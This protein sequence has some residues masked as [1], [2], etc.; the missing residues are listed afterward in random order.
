MF[1]QRQASRGQRGRLLLM[2]LS[3]CLVVITAAGCASRA[4]LSAAGTAASKLPAVES[5]P[6]T[7]RPTANP[8]DA[9]DPNLAPDE[10]GIA[11]NPDVPFN[12]PTPPPA[13]AATD[14][15]E[16]ARTDGII[17]LPPAIQVGE[18][19]EFAPTTP[20]SRTATGI[21]DAVVA[22]LKANDWPTLYNLA[23]DSL[24][25]G[26]TS[27]Q[28]AQQVAVAFGAGTRITD[29]HTTGPITYI[30]NEASV[31]YADVPVSFTVLSNGASQTAAG[32][33]VLIN[34]QG[35]W[36]WLTTKPAGS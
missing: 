23:D 32:T 27:T 29:V 7:D 35:S 6:T 18:A 9:A 31:S 28:F 12:P 21:A 17:M 3:A 19:S 33:L 11:M 36:R 26:M 1:N 2:A 25:L 4:A 16:A 30:T 22:A 20:S 5:H 10:T 8:L 13:P 14:D 34:D 15:P 24:R